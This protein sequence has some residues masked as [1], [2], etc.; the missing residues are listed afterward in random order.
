MTAG[1]PS[2]LTHATTD[3]PALCLACAWGVH[4]WPRGGT[5]GAAQRPRERHVPARHRE[6]VQ[7]ESRR[8]KPR[9]GLPAAARGRRGDEAGRDGGGRHRW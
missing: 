3:R 9:C 1:T 7:A 5:T 4:P 2:R 6:A 8:A